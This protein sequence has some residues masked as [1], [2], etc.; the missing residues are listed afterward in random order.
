M[1][2]LMIEHH[3]PPTGHRELR[4]RGRAR[5]SLQAWRFVHRAA[6]AFDAYAT[7][8]STPLPRGCEQRGVT[9]FMA[10]PDAVAANE[11]TSER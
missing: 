3:G 5:A 1:T 9:A 8:R 2:T 11:A 7:S 6:P 10:A 4:R